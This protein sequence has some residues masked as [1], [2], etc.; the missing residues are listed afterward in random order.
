MSRPGGRKPN[1]LRNVKITPHYQRHAEGSALIEVGN[2][3]VICSASVAPGVPRWRRDSGL[4][5]ITAEYGMLP[6]AT[7]DRTER[8]RG[9]ISGR[10]SE[11]QRLIG[12]SLRATVDMSEM[13]EFTI[14][15]DCDVI[16]ADGGTRTASIT[17]ASVALWMALE[18]MR[19]RLNLSAHPMKKHVVAVSV[20]LV[21]GEARIDLEY[22]EDTAAEVDMNVVMTG[23]GDFVEIQGTGEESTFSDQDLQAMLSL[24]KGGVRILN[25]V[26]LE[27]CR[28]GADRLDED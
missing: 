5:W 1:V 25:G 23:D 16:E 7:H 12:R 3:R 27:A 10:S 6:R 20:G 11:I 4:G 21:E 13:G 17:G 26:Q 18:R 8:E 14:T 22:E 2:T 15:V 28:L 24:A 19:R 9:R